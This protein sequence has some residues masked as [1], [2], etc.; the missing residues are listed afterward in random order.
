MTIHSLRL[1]VYHAMRQFYIYSQLSMP[2]PHQKT[3]LLYKC[4]TVAPN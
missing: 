1:S 3:D 2:N 4:K